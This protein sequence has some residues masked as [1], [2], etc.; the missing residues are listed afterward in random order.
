MHQT[1]LKAASGILAY[2]M[3]FSPFGFK[4]GEKNETPS[5]PTGEEKIVYVAPNGNDTDG[6]GSEEAPFATLEGARDA[7][8]KLD[9]SKYDGITVLVKEGEYV[10]TKSLKLTA[11]DAGTKNCPIKYVGEDGAEFIGGILLTAED[12]TKTSGGLTEYFPEEAKDKI[13]MVDLTK[14]GYTADML[15]KNMESS[16]YHTQVPFLSVNGERQTLAQYPNNTWIH[17]GETV[18]HSEDGTTDTAIDRVTRQTI[19]YPEEYFANV[20]SWSQVLTVFTRGRIYKLWCPSD[21]VVVDISKTEPKFDQTFGGD[22]DPAVGTILY[23]YNI[24]EELDIPGEYIYDENAVLYYYPDE[25]FDTAI[26]SV[27]LVES[28]FDIDGAD[29]TTVENLSLT[30]SN[31][32]GVVVNANN[33]TI[34]GCEI[35][36]VKGTAIAATGNAITIENCSIHDIGDNAISLRSGDTASATGGKSRVYNNDIY[37]YSVTGAYG[38]G[39]TVG[40]VEILVDHNDVHDANFKGI[41]VANS[42]NTTVEYNEL[43]NLERLTEDVGVLSGDGK[44]NANVVFRYNY[45][46]NCFPTGEAAKIKEYNPDYH[47]MGT[48]GIY[49][50]GGCSYIECYGNIVESV[51]TGYLSNGGRGNSL[52]NNLFIDCRKWYV[53]FS[54]FDFDPEVRDGKATGGQSLESYVYN[55]TWKKLNPELSKLITSY[56]D[57]DANDSLLIHAP[58]GNVCENNWIHYNKAERAFTNWGVKPYNIENWVSLHSTDGM[59]YDENQL[60]TYSSKRE[61]VN[62]KELIEVTAAGVVDMTWERFQTIGRVGD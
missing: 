11:E 42:V 31:N 23:W 48:Y 30:S 43:W 5:V 21:S 46:H 17:I 39:V 29:Y 36:S 1:V 7:V 55:D 32:K 49:F 52:H 16:I 10:L 56:T 38:Y 2:V 44:H 28:F 4:S 45:V 18:T 57:A 37:E 33:V 41:H 12:F 40:G 13:V 61:E 47:D 58:A 51:D 62:L 54:H 27:P 26:M 53:S 9:K 8:R 22:H 59:K 3:M 24:P 60:S 50:D 34:N 15:K 25:N 20:S 6:N 19:S 14:Y 35:T